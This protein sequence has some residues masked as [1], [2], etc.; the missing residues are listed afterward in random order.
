MAILVLHN[1]L[2]L[3]VGTTGF[4]PATPASRTRCSTRLSHVPTTKGIYLKE[5]LQASVILG[6]QPVHEI[7]QSRFHITPLQGSDSAEERIIS[8]KF[9]MI[10]AVAPQIT[11]PPKEYARFR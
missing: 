4:E 2:I 3:L 1:L 6:F 8:T 9:R 10:L 5:T 7:C 11:S